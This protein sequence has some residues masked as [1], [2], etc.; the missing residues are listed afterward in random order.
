MFINLSKNSFFHYLCHCSCLCIED[1][2]FTTLQTLYNMNEKLLLTARRDRMGLTTKAYKQFRPQEEE[3]DSMYDELVLYWD[4]ML[5]ELSVLN[6]DPTVMRSHD[7]VEGGGDG[8]SDCLLFWP[9][10]QELFANV[11]RILLNRRLPNPDAPDLQDI[12]ACIRVLSKVNWELGQLPWFGLLLIE[13]PEPKRR[14]MRNEDRKRAIDVA[15]R[16]LLLQTGVDDATPDRL[17]ELKVDWHAM[18]MPR[19]D[20]EHVDAMWEAISRP[21]L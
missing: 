11:I 8:L 14:R 16:I 2:Y 21:V 9:I 1:S 13:D 20:L 6:S 15:Q 3:L 12:C 18:L 4:A 5:K 17:S 19:P 7:T 10:G